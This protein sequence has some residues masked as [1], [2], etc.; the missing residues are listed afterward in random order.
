MRQNTNHETISK[1]TQARK[2][3][4]FQFDR[5]PIFVRITEFFFSSFLPAFLGNMARS[6]MKANVTLVKKLITYPI[7]CDAEKME[8]I[9]CDTETKNY[10][11][12]HRSSNHLTARNLLGSDLG[13]IWYGTNI[14]EY[15]EADSFRYERFVPCTITD[16]IL[17]QFNRN[18][19]EWNGDEG[20]RTREGMGCRGQKGNN[21]NII[22]NKNNNNSIISRKIYRIM[23]E[24][25]ARA[26]WMKKESLLIPE[27]KAIT[28]TNFNLI[29][30]IC[31]T[32]YWI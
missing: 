25:W 2:S 18:G 3:Q 24:K 9:R 16:Y 5:K 30:P 4:S 10:S 7:E 20:N 13:E 6:W 28:K 19:K 22:I 27:T 26:E 23:S 1:S 15:I 31:W 32:L 8:G 21:I 12:N 29:T 14:D 11:F 17:R